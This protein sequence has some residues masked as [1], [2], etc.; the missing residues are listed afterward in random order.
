MKNR[1][2]LKVIPIIIGLN[3]ILYVLNILSIGGNLI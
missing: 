2:P 3:I 1:N